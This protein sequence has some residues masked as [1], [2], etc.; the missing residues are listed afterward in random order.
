[1]ASH[2]TSVPN[3][4]IHHTSRPRSPPCSCS[5]GASPS[6]GH[7]PATRHSPIALVPG[8]HPPHGR[9]AF[10]QGP[11][12]R[13]LTPDPN[14]CHLSAAGNNQSR[15]WGG[16]DWHCAAEP[17]SYICRLRERIDRPVAYPHAKIIVGVGSRTLLEDGLP[18][19]PQ[20]TSSPTCCQ[21]E[22][23]GELPCR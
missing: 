14:A 6:P 18:A 12:Q 3:P 2:P 20:Q 9:L 1:M 13:V 23:A 11:Y 8:G 4:S 19:L 10:D 17:R 5:R 21:R 16:R 7:C 22:S 15:G